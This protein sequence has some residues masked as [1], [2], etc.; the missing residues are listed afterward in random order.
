MFSH[1]K[2]NSISYFGHMK[3]AMKYFTCLQVC[4]IKILIHAF[5][6]DIFTNDASNEICRLHKEMQG[7]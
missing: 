4:A 3:L 6:P 2:E 7:E 5:L 1:L